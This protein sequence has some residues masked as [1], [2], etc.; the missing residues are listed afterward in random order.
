M[1]FRNIV[2][3]CALIFSGSLLLAQGPDL[4]NMDI[5]KIKVEELSDGQI[6]QILERAE[7]SGMTEAQMKV[8]LRTRGMAPSEIR[9]LEERLKSMQ[10]EPSGVDIAGRSR[11][12]VLESK[13]EDVF[14]PLLERELGE[15]SAEETGPESRIFGYN[16]FR[17][18]YL[19]F[20]PGMNIPTPPDYQ[21]GP[22]DQLIIDVWG[23]SQQNYQL[24]VSPEGSVY[25]ESLGPIQVAGLTMEK[26]SERILGRLKSIYSGLSGPGRNT[27]AEVTL[28]NIRTI[29]V[30]ILGEVNLPG[31]FTLSS[32]A[33][34]FNALHASGGPAL[35]GSFRDIE[36]FRNNQRIA[37]MDVY[38]FLIHGKQ[39][40]NMRLQDQDII[41]VNPY[42]TRVDITGEIKRPGL[43]ELST[44]ES[45]DRLIDYSGG[46]TDKAYKKRLT[47]YRKT[48]TERKIM[49]LEKEEAETFSLQDGD[50][51]PVSKILNRFENRVT[52]SGAV[53]RPGEYALSDELTLR[54]LIGKAE[55]L[56]DDAF[57]ARGLIY[58]TRADFTLEIIPVNLRTMLEDPG[59][60]VR[61]H[62]D[63]VIS[64]S[65]IFDLREEYFIELSGEVNSPGVY[66]YMENSTL[67]DLIVMAGGLKE[68]ATPTRVEV[69]RRFK[70]AEKED[71]PQDKIAE[72]FY[73]DIDRNLELTDGGEK[74]IMEP[75]DQ[76]FIRKSPGYE[77]AQ[78]I[79]ISGEVLY[80]GSY[81]ISTKEEKISDLIT[82]AGGLTSEAYPEGAKLIRR[83]PVNQEERL[84]ALESLMRESED[85]LVFNIEEENEQA[86]GIDLK[87]ILESPGSKY[88]LLVQDQDRIEIPVEM[89]TVRLSGALLYPVSVRYD[90][91][92][93]FSSYIARSGGFA[94]DAKRSKSYVIYANGSV[95][96]TSKFLFFN[97]YPKIEPGAEIV[98]PQKPPKDKIS[99]QEVVGIS[100]A[101]SSMAL[102]IVTII[103]SFGGG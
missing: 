83:L 103:N 71:S 13:K 94:S 31:T 38:D 54:E 21:I 82:R 87:T 33:T 15:D 57:L 28:G 7:G 67:E 45:L 99:T 11:Q 6:Q 63:D 73:F 30:H 56:R 58:R 68:S 39:D 23:A 26:A 24:P 18:E 40:G 8:A 93:T 51:I 10:S 4:Q 34:V 70:S 12:A 5:S 36:L 75:F 17:N 14:G 69:A 77:T 41:K 79:T 22:G 9:K 65:S 52:I 60:S 86:I 59:S 43:Y 19:T 89:Q 95:D 47:V 76:V 3:C 29:S 100:S 50:S 84:K 20:E 64:I 44:E 88:D 102:I 81:S 61:L 97:L 48:D 72:I 53:Y 16:L 37:S 66:P 90:K 25:I 92:F 85:S 96:R 80:P 32:F 74:F 101:L 1:I 46:F 78:A 55:G 27:Y 42:K 2:F 62:K 91:S 49:N 98:V 35:N